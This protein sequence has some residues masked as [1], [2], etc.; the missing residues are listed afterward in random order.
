MKFDVISMII[1]ALLSFVIMFMWNRFKKMS[2]YDIPTFTDDMT[3]EQAQALQEK[4]AK[5][6]ADDLTARQAAAG[7][8]EAAVGVATKE[9]QDAMVK[10]AGEFGAF[11]TRKSMVPVSAPAA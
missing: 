5:M 4:T 3:M 6:L 11:S 2:Y 10:L 7:N 8:D 9:V 1:G